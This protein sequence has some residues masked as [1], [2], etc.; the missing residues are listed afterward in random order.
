MS[1][2]AWT[3]AGGVVA[4]CGTVLVSYLKTRTQTKAVSDKVDTASAAAAT[5]ATAAATAVDNTV[6]VSNGYT[7]KTL[8]LL[9]GIR[10]DL[11]E[12]RQEAAADRAVMT[13]HLGD[14][15]RAGMSVPAQGQPVEAPTA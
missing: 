12:M 3:F 15:A 14:H 7:G 11:R 9:E 5:A 13:T 1:P 6:A 2:E 8:S 4:V 10:S